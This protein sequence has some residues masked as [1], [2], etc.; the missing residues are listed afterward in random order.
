MPLEGSEVNPEP[1][2]LQNSI[3]ALHVVHHIM[4]SIKKEASDDTVPGLVV[5]IGIVR[6]KEFANDRAEFDVVEAFE[7]CCWRHI[8]HQN[9][10]EGVIRALQ[11]AQVVNEGENGAFF[12]FLRLIQDILARQRHLV[13]AFIP[14]STIAS[15][16]E[17]VRKA[18]HSTPRI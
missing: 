5:S 3:N 2:P 4:S 14:F 8:G 10:G 11:V 9:L 18:T 13:S 6:I 17:L 12:S 15:L 7:L 1:T 16:S